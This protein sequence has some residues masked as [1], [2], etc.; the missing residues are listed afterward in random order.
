MAAGRVVPCLRRDR[1][2][3]PPPVGETPGRESPDPRRPGGSSAV[4]SQVVEGETLS[5]DLE[6]GELAGGSLPPADTPPVVGPDIRLSVGL[7]GPPSIL[8]RSSPVVQ[9][10]GRGVARRDVASRVG[11][12]VTVVRRVVTDETLGG[13]PDTLGDGP[14][15]VRRR[16]PTGEVG[17]PR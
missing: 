9:N 1:G 4:R 13:R 5:T 14:P 16:R 17:P 2:P 10:N 8:S 7:V 15:D 12:V 3:G 11:V 6:V